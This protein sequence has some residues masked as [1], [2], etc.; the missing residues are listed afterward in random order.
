VIAGE[1][2]ALRGLGRTDAVFLG[3]LIALAAACS[4][5][6]DK[7]RTVDMAPAFARYSDGGPQSNGGPVTATR[8]AR[9]EPW[10]VDPDAS[11]PHP[12]QVMVTRT[13]ALEAGA[14]AVTTPKAVNP[15]DAVLERARVAAGSCFQSLSAGA[16]A[17]PERSAHIV[18]TVIPT[19]MV[20]TAD[21]TSADTDDD[22]VLGCIRQQ[23]LHTVFSDN[24]G[25]PLR[26]Y[27]IDVRVVAKL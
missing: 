6:D 2:R 13:I 20:T 19:G 21:V 8:V 10:P 17:P 12:L 7:P 9:D 18:F 3:G 16:G 4:R 11:R 14:G 15:D 27:A 22:G 23:A 25:G 26:S 1:R 5:E 24:G